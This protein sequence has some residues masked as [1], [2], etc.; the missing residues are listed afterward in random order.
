MALYYTGRNFE[1]CRLIFRLHLSTSQMRPVVTDRVASSVSVCLSIGL[2]QPLAP[3]KQLNRSRC[4]LGEDSDG[5]KE[6][7]IRWSPDPQ[8]RRGNFEGQNVAGPGHARTCP[9][10]DM[11]K[12]TQ[13]GAAPVWF[14]CRLGVLDGSAHWRRLANTIEP[15][16]CGCDAAFCQILSPT[17]TVVNLKHTVTLC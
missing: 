11:L 7:C 14:G 2:S 12:P 4:R 16:V 8:T 3:Q 1:K 15:S 6:S 5:P 17:D 13:Q 9:A 10:L